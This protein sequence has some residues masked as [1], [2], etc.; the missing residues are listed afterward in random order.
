MKL[1]ERKEEYVLD[2]ININVTYGLYN[3]TNK[4]NY[5][6]TAEIRQISID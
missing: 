4:Q 6:N 3:E 1:K 2:R 5:V